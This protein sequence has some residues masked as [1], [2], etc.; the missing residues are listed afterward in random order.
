MRVETIGAATLYLGDARA[1]APTLGAVDCCKIAPND[2]P[3]NK[4]LNLL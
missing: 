2:D 1:I 4:S 3:A